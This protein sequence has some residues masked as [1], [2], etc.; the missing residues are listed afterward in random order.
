LLGAWAVQSNPSIALPAAY[1]TQT[2]WHVTAIRW[3]S[4]QV[5]VL[6]DNVINSSDS[7]NMW[8]V[9]SDDGGTTWT[10]P[11]VPFLAGSWY[12][13]AVVAAFETRAQGFDVLLG[14]LTGA[15]W[16]LYRGTATLAPLTY[17]GVGSNAVPSHAANVAAA[18]K[19]VTP[20]TVGDTA[21]RADSA[22]VIGT[23][24]SGQTFTVASG[25]WGIASKQIYVAVSA[26]NNKVT[27][28]LTG[29][30]DGVF[31]CEFSAIDTAIQQ[32]FIIRNVD[33]N[34][35]VRLGYA[36]TGKYKIEN[37]V[38]GGVSQSSVS[39]LVGPV[40]GDILTA[41][42]I[43]SAVTVYANGAKIL[44]VTGW[45]ANASGTG[46]GLQSNGVSGARW[47]NIYARPLVNGQ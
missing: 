8:V 23:L 12:R 41:V 28:A 42:A 47:R 4:R 29:N 36:T 32:F 39:T 27:L 10:V 30:A 19:P 14:N 26:G 20:Y 38:A 37:I 5:L 31:G 16:S 6:Q 34:N 24:D 45:S 18:A 9:W 13:S 21:N 43:G 44:G 35:F 1:S 46:I 15:V 33:A 2:W 7:G 11:A 22:V 25:T 40:A 17:G 3:G